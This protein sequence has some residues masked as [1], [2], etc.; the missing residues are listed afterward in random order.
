MIQLSSTV[1]SCLTPCTAQ[2]LE[3]WGP[4]YVWQ[5]NEYGKGHNPLLSSI[6]PK[7]KDE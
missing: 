7:I 4:I 1:T 5:G 6:L 2:T 3:F